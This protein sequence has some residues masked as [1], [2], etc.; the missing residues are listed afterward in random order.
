MGV[1]PGL[2]GQLEGLALVELAEGVDGLKIG[3][4]QSGIDG[5]LL[6]LDL[7][8][9]VV[10]DVGAGGECEG[11]VVEGMDSP[12]NDVFEVDALQGAVEA[13]ALDLGID[14]RVVGAVDGEPV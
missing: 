1:L 9:A 8:Y 7:F 13:L 12:L 3:L 11:S 4:E 5:W 10:V 14:H 2:G 6:A